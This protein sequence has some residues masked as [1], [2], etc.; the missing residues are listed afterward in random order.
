MSRPA[1]QLTAMSPE[2]YLEMERS[3]PLKH[4]YVAG[5]VFA[6]TGTSVVHNVIL[7]NLY[8]ALRSHLKGTPCR[9]FMADVKLKVEAADAFYYPD[10]MVTC[11]PAPDSH[12]RQQPTLVV[13]VLSESTA[14][15]D[16]G[17]KRLDYQK[18][19]SLQE[20]LLVAQECMDIRLY[21]REQERWRMT[22]FTDGAVIPLQSVGM[23]IPIEAVYEEVW[24]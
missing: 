6:M 22:V 17:A 7:G 23:E 11:E 5:Q 21:R 16:A 10:L 20:Y 13:E 1:T 9:V 19:E 3:S 8:I 24:Q 18:L 2:A 4:E 14:A 12:Y 15:Y